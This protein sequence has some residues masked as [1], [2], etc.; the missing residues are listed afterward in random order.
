MGTSGR[1][2]HCRSKNFR[3]R[4][5]VWVAYVMKQTHATKKQFKFWRKDGSFVSGKQLET[6][7]LM[8]LGAYHAG[9]ERD[10]LCFLYQ[11]SRRDWQK[12]VDCFYKQPI[13]KQAKA[14]M[15]ASRT[16]AKYAQRSSRQIV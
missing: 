7:S 12:I 8:V 5:V 2:N 1:K 10:A 11:L 15:T 14:C 9:I 4:S 16:I 13:D 6:K 3:S